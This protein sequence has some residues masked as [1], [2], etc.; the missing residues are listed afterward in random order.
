MTDDQWEMLLRVI[1]G[2][3]QPILPV[4]F[5]V[6]GPWV[7]S[8]H[9]VSLLDYYGDDR[10][11]LEANLD[12][13]HRFP[14]TMFMAGFWAEYGMI[15]NPPSFGCKCVWPEQG[16]PTC[17]PVL[18]GCEQIDALRKPNAATDGLL[19]LLV[20]RLRRNRRAIEQAGHRIRFATSH[21]PL[22]IASYLLGHTQFFLT[23]KSEPQAIDRLLD[24]VTEFVCDWLSLQCGEFSTIDGLLVLEDLMGFVGP[25]D[26]GRF[27]LPHMKRIFATADVAVRFLHNDAYGTITAEHLDAM[28]VNLFNFSFE[29]S[30]EEIRRLAGPRVTLMGNIPPRDVLALGTCEQVQEAVL[31]TFGR[32][33]DRRRVLA[34]AGGFVLPGVSDEKIDRFLTAVAQC[35]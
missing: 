9:G 32:L 33:D 4:A 31:D 2:E 24:R 22:T 21:G 17:E 1:A 3:P 14:H 25:N 30:L 26:F 27:V 35:R 29:H 8:R 19:P 16:F 6:D 10:I 18:A 11:W 34:S 23:M 13:V 5:L 12:L 20:G 7:A 28:G 15:S